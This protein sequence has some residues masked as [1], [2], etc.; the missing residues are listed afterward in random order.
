MRVSSLRLAPWPCFRVVV[1]GTI[2]FFALVCGLLTHTT[3]FAQAWTQPAGRTYM[4]VSSQSAT[5]SQQFRSDGTRAPYAAG[6]D[7]NGFEDNSLYL[8]AETGLWSD[9]TL[10]LLVPY[11]R[12]TVRSANPLRTSG[13]P[14]SDRPVETSASGIEK[15]QVGLRWN[16]SRLFGLNPESRH[17]TALNVSMRLPAFYSRDAVPALGPGQ[18]DLEAVI[19][20]GLSFWP[21]PVYTQIGTGYR[22]RSSLFGLSGGDSGGPAYGNEWLVHGEA[23]LTLGRWALIQGLVL[24]VFSNQPAD[25]AF[26]PENPLP[27]HQRYLKVGGGVVLYPVPRLGISLQLFQTVDGANTIRSTDRFLGLEAR[28]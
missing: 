22:I 24:G 10:V 12:F 25:G 16:T 26:D 19:F 2:A 1:R 15:V 27:T 14:G 13:L 7:G 9:L 8:Y 20:Y 23:G 18:I 3:V 4:K 6:V 21:A 11:K 17:R 28:F 5:A